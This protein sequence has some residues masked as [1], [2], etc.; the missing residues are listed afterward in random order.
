MKTIGEKLNGQYILLDCPLCDRK[1][2]KKVILN[3]ITKCDNTRCSILVDMQQHSSGDILTTFSVN[4][5]TVNAAVIEVN[6]ISKKNKNDLNS[7]DY[8][9]TIN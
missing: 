3:K 1:W 9:N 4:P 7:N 6:I 5:K 8:N 2:S